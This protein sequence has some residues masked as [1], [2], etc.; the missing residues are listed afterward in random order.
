MSELDLLLIN[1]GTAAPICSKTQTPLNIGS[2]VCRAEMTSGQQVE[3]LFLLVHLAV[4]EV[5]KNTRGKRNNGYRSVV[6]HKMRVVGQW[7]ERLGKRSRESSGEELHGLHERPHVLG[8]L[9]EGVL[10]RSHRGEDL[11]DGNQDVNTSNS[12]DVDGR[13]VLGI[14]RVIVESRGL[15]DIVLKNGSP[16]HGEGRD[17]ETSGDLLDGSELDAVLAERGV[18]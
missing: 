1:D 17:D 5:E 15:V 16:N 8:C 11:G 12:P 10:E 4:C 3:C 6:P 2:F 7:S 18:D 9:G 13:L 14:G